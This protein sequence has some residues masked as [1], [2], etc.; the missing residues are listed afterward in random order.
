M[1]GIYN[2]KTNPIRLRDVEDLCNEIEYVNHKYDI[3]R[4][5]FVDPTWAFPVESVI[6]FCDEY[7]KRNIELPWEAM[8]HAAYLT[9]DIMS[10][11][12]SS[13]C[14]QLNIG[15]ESGNQQILNSI[16]KGVTIDKI[17]KVFYWGKKVGINMRAFFMI[18]YP[19]ETEETIKDTINLI[20]QIE[21][22]VFGCTIL[23]PYPGSDFY[24]EEF[25][26]EDWSNANEYNN[27]FWYSKNY[28]NCGLKRI[29]KLLNERFN[30][31]LVGHQK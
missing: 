5:K 6:S 2:A 7:N 8:A 11:M 12:A 10:Y 22:D 17:K 9:E 21:P 23:T 24:R 31:I 3:T 14:D 16:R 30:H 28:P 29:Q 25:K 26:H 1:T 15:V 13:G 19:D 20:E 4:I 27:D 18:G